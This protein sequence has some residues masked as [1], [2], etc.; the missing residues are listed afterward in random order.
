LKTAI[1]I[2]KAQI[3]DFW[4]KKIGGFYFTSND[5]EELLTRQKEIYD[6]AIP[7]GNSIAMLNL[8]RLSY[9]TGD[10]ELEI[11]AEILNRVFSEKVK[12][13]PIAYT[14]FL[15]AVDFAIGPTYSLVISGDSEAEDTK[16]LIQSILNEF[17]P[18]KVFI[19]RN[20]EKDNPDIDK[21][22]NFVEFFYKL[23]GKATAYVCI[24][25]TCKPPTHD[26]NQAIE[27]LKPNWQ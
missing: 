16:N 9:I 10:H 25:K 24:N 21:Y 8:L 7:S 15:V 20:M 12:A 13:N 19:L 4:D 14:Q 1:E 5:S 27:Y 26:I 11:K 2:H 6:G 22:S 18:N 23:E 3:E 17:V